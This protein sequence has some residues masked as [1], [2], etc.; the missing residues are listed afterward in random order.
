MNLEILIDND[1]I[2]EISE[3][4]DNSNIEKKIDAKG[5]VITPSFIDCHTHPIF[6]GNISAKKTSASPSFAS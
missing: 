3:N 5:G 4:I 1:T 6:S 2:V